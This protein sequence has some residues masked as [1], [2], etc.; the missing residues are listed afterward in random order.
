MNFRAKRTDTEELIEG[1][2]CEVGVSYILPHGKTLASHFIEVDPN[3][4]EIEFAG[5]WFTEKDI[6]TTIETIKEVLK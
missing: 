5:I 3:T 4:L 2:Y 6:V 1:W